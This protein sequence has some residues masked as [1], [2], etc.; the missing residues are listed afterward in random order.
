[1]RAREFVNRSLN[2]FAPGSGG[3]DGEEETLYKYAR[4]WYNGDDATQQQV[5][6][7]LA[8]AGW[9][10]GEIESEEGGAFVV[11][12]GDENG[13]SYIGFTGDDLTEQQLDELTFMGMSPCTKDCSGHRAGYKWSKARGGVSTA[14]WSDSF[15]KGAEIAKAGY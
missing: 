5:E 15:N 2:E 1:M 6:Q 14:S 13:R 12:A 7:V 3:D 10:I 9:E 8:R 4:M 11:Q